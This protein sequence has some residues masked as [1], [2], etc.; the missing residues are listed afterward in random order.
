MPDPTVKRFLR[1]W[2]LALAILGLAAI[3]YAAGNLLPTAPPPQPTSV[4][5]SATSA[6]DRVAWGRELFQQHCSVCHGPGGS[7]D[8]MAAYLLNP[9]P[10]NLASGQFRIVR[11]ASGLARREDIQ[12]V[13]TE[14]MPGSAMPPWDRL[15]EDERWALTDYTLSLHQNREKIVAKKGLEPFTPG[16]EVPVTEQG[17]ARGKE[18][19]AQAC[20]LCHGPSGLGNGP[21]KQFDSDG[22]PTR[23]R[24]LTL[25]LYKGGDSGE[26]IYRRIRL[27]IPGSPMPALDSLSNEDMWHLVHFVKS[28]AKRDSQATVRQSF[29]KLEAPRLKKSLPDEPL[30]PE[31]LEQPAV[32][33]ALMPLWWRDSRIETVEVRAGWDGEDLLVHMT[34]MDATHDELQLRT[35][36]F[37]DGVAVQF[38]AESAPPIFAMGAAGASDVRL[39]LWK[40]SFQRDADGGFAD[41]QVAHPNAYATHYQHMTSGPTAQANPISANL[42][43][44]DAT[45]L[46]GRGAGNIV[47][48]PHAQP[49][50]S[51]SAHGMGTVGRRPQN[52][53]GLRARGTWKDGKYGVLMRR[54]L[55]Q[56]GPGALTLNAGDTFHVAFA[57]WDGSQG[58]RNGQKSVTIWHALHLAP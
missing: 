55:R 22:N 15:S 28:L 12:K 13:L 16:P 43:G 21:Q 40:A 30:A 8:G 44:H 18:L 29:Q 51:L 4:P 20:A 25:G 42:D 37:P 45:F 39:W 5:F 54:P 3:L 56:S 2:P 14:G 24:N 9:K 33:L 41:L 58:D 23:P 50:E 35:E 17:L 31:W 1:P 34:W 6:V 7:G 32:A 10:R 19:F 26:E 53:M 57:V 36:G 47:S 46:T 27:G 38:T 49:I 52:D 11:T 48:T